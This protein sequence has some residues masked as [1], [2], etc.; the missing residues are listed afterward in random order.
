MKQLFY[1]LIIFATLSGCYKDNGEPLRKFTEF[2]LGTSY[3]TIPCQ[4]TT[5]RN[6]ATFGDGS[7]QDFTT[8]DNGSYFITERIFNSDLY[9]FEGDFFID[10]DRSAYYNTTTNDYDSKKMRFF[11]KKRYPNRTYICESGRKMYVK[12]D[13]TGDG[14][15]FYFC[16]GT[17]FNVTDATDSVVVSHA[18]FYYN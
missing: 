10:P 12:L 7:S 8:L 9:V 17:F 4:T 5:V 14:K 3:D 18:Q 6:E 15:A 2:D 11:V 16:G 1:T 13:E